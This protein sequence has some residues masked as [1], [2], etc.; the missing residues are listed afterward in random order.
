MGGS[1]AVSADQLQDVIR[2]HVAQSAR[3]IVIAAAL[4]DADRFRDGDLHVID[5]AAI[6]DR[7]ENTVGE[8]KHQDVLDGFFA[9]VMIDAVDLLFADDLQRVAG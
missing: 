2:H 6:P 5:V 1:I 8:T 3:L 4:F 9:E 7:L